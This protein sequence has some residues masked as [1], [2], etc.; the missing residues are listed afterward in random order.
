MGSMLSTLGVP[1]GKSLAVLGDLAA[2]RVHIPVGQEDQALRGTSNHNLRGSPE[3]RVDTQG[4]LICSQ[5]DM[6]RQVGK[7][8]RE[9]LGNPE[10]T[11]IPGNILD[12]VLED[13]QQGS[14]FLDSMEGMDR[15]GISEDT[16][17]LGNKEDMA[18]AGR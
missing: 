13:I 6:V 18:F 1:K 14:S 16:G 2:P 12:K 5:V 17:L 4:I 10:D 9:C 7:E 11:G 8:G 3:V 15:R